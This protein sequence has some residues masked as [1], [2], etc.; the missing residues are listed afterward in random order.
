MYYLVYVKLGDFH[1]VEIFSV[2]EVSG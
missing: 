1:V 2:I